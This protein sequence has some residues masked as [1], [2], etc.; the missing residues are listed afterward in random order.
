MISD[1]Q[2]AIAYFLKSCSYKKFISMISFKKFFLIKRRY[3]GNQCLDLAWDRI[4]VCQIAAFITTLNW[5]VA[6]Q[7]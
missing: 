1:V 7:R 3:Y 4:K 5:L 2:G 6:S